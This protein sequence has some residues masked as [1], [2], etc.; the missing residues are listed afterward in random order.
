MIIVGELGLSYTKNV[1]AIR[2]SLPCITIKQGECVCATALTQASALGTKKLKTPL[3]STCGASP[4][5]CRTEE[6]SDNIFLQCS[7]KEFITT[8]C[9]VQF[10]RLAKGDMRPSIIR[11]SQQ[12][13]NGEETRSPIGRENRITSFLRMCSACKRTDCQV[14]WQHTVDAGWTPTS[15]KKPMKKKVGEVP[16]LQYFLWII[17]GASNSFDWFL[18]LVTLTLTKMGR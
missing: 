4:S 3:P 12:H 15:S 6:T 5:L 13:V 2:I 14:A 16:R 9:F 1:I 10:A 11:I 17:F 8:Q 18:R 7:Q